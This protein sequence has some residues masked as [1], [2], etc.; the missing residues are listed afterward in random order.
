ME[1]DSLGWLGVAHELPN[2]VLRAYRVVQ[3]GQITMTFSLIDFQKQSNQA[4]SG[5]PKV[6]FFSSLIKIESNPMDV[7]I[8]LF[9]YLSTFATG[10][11]GGF[12]A[13]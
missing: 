2:T 10:W 12:I 3:F 7:M 11:R 8:N 6:G 5:L 9:F 4:I 1:G 13:P